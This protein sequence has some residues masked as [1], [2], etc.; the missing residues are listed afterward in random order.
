MRAERSCEECHSSVTLV[1]PGWSLRGWL[2][3]RGELRRWKRD[4]IPRYVSYGRE[5]QI[6]EWPKPPY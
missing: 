2:W 5:E 4:H 6:L 1:W 3:A